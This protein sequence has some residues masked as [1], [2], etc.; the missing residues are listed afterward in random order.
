MEI[1]KELKKGKNNKGNKINDKKQG[2]SSETGG[3]TQMIWK[4]TKKIGCASAL[5]KG[6]D[7]SYAVCVYYPAGNW[8]GEFEE[9]VF[10][11]L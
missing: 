5:V 11:P 8:E 1:I 2:W 6:Q 10:P 9:N 7:K 4:A 3:F